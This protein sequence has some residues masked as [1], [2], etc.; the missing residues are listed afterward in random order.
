MRDDE[1][2]PYVKE[3]KKIDFFFLQIYI[4]YIKREMG[5]VPWGNSFDRFIYILIFLSIVQLIYNF[6]SI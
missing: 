1:G 4:T 5:R 2:L 3:R 6:Y